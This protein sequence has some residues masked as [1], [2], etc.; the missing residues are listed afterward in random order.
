MI[1]TAPQHPDVV[2]DISYAELE[3]YFE[4]TRPE[5]DSLLN[6]GL[7]LSQIRQL[8]RDQYKATTH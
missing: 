8:R 5:V 1:I 3:I 6:Q 7:T 4:L 2:N